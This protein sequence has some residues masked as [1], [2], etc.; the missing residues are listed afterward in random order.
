MSHAISSQRL[1][2]YQK[3][4]QIVKIETERLGHTSK[5][6]KINSALDRLL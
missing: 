3:L 1:S 6:Q 4:E 2:S 5:A